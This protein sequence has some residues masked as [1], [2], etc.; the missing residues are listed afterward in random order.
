[1]EGCE[2]AVTLKLDDRNLVSFVRPSNSDAAV[3]QSCMKERLHY[4]C[5]PQMIIPMDEFPRTTRGKIDKRA[6]LDIA[7]KKQTS[8]NLENV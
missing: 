3:F 8:V 1:M 4:Y 2:Q 7:L 5:V 6:L